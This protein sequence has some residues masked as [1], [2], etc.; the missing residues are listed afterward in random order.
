VLATSVS[1]RV[2]LAQRDSSSA[3]CVYVALRS[4]PLTR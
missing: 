3:S 1:N 4:L 2:K